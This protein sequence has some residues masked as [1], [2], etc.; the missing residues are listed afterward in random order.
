MAIDKKQLIESLEKIFR[1]V[2]WDNRKNIRKE[3]DL[4]YSYLESLNDTYFDDP[5]VIEAE[6]N[7]KYI[8]QQRNR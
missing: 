4:I 3:F 6:F 5:N 7:E 1:N 8:H 2:P